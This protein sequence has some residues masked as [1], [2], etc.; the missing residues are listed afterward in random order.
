MRVVFN[1]RKRSPS[2]P[3]TVTVRMDMS[4]TDTVAEQN[5]GEDI[6]ADLRR[7]WA[8]GLYNERGEDPRRIF[9]C[10]I[11]PKGGAL[12]PPKRSQQH[13]TG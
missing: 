5:M 7:K 6:F 3:C 10:R 2:A 8:Q 1:I 11:E 13:G 9:H 4:S 12:M